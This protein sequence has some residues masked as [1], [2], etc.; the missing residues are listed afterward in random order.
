M[1]IARNT[2]KTIEISIDSSRIY[3]IWETE[4]T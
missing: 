2:T 3:W 1:E 4:R